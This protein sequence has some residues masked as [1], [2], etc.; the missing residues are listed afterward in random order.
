MISYTIEIRTP[1]A[2]EFASL[3]DETSWGGLTLTQAEQ[4]LAQS[5]CG[6]SVYADGEIIGMIR[7]VG[8]GVLILYVQDV[9]VAKEYRCN[10]IGRDMMEHLIHYLKDHYPKDCYVGLMA[11]KGQSAFYERFGFEVRPS[12]TTDAGMLSSLNGLHSCLAKSTATA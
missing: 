9:I 4:A 5:L 6:T 8:D 2:A 10:G 12:A 1:E 3:R 7:V 11:A